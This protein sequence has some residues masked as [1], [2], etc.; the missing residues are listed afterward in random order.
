[1]AEKTRIGAAG[2][3]WDTDRR[4]NLAVK[5]Q[6]NRKEQKEKSSFEMGGALVQERWWLPRN[7]RMPKEVGFGG[8][9]TPTSPF[10]A[11]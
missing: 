11:K 4:I 5:S 8:S 1:M 3:N 9:P 7:G 10:P 6:G 2:G